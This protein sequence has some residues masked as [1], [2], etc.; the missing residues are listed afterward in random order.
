[1]YVARILIVEDDLFLRELYAEVLIGDGY[2]VETAADGAEGLSKIKEGG[3]N[4]VLLDINLP[5]IN[6]FEIMEQVKK[7]PNP[8]P[9]FKG[10]V[11]FLTNIDK[12]EGIKK[13]LLLADGYLIK[14]QI[15][16]ASLS[17]EIKK[18]LEKR[19]QNF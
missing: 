5:K 1:M 9:N 14:S 7:D 6:G 10:S 8:E 4:I 19:Q 17:A 11:I 13:G 3:Y 15:T 2:R 16:P 18:Q 12:D